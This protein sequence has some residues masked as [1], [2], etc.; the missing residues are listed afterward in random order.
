MTNVIDKIEESKLV[1]RKKNDTDRRAIRVG[2]TDE[3]KNILEGVAKGYY[4]LL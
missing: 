4:A 2:V 1:E 3:G